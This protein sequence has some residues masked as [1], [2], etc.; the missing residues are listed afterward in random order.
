VRGPAAAQ[1]AAR[2]ATSQAGVRTHR[3]LGALATEWNAIAG[4][5]GNLFQTHEWLSGWWR[6][7]GEGDPSW[8]VLHDRDGS[9]RAGACL[10]PLR[11]NGMTSAANVHSGMWDVL[12]RDEAARA[13]LW[14]AIAGLGA[15]RLHLRGLP[16]AGPS[17]PLVRE[18]LRRAGYRVLSTPG[19]F[20]PW[21]KLPGTWE[22][23][24]GSLSSSMRS[25]MRRTE[26]TLEKRGS[27]TFA[28]ATA[29]AQLERQLERFIA[30]ESS[31]WKG[32]NGS[33][34]A[35]KP[36]TAGLYRD[37]ARAAARRGWM[38]LHTLELDGELIAASFACVFGGECVLLKS[39]FDERRRDLSPG[40]YLLARMIRSAIE[41]EHASS[42]DFLG[43]ADR[44]KLRWAPE[45]RPRMT[46]WAYRGVASPGYTL[47]RRVRPLVKSV[48]DRIRS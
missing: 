36:A 44:Y 28:T 8:M 25:S 47:R 37:F 40:R 23:L 21:L 30:L 20:S 48:R 7:F 18:D 33:A 43:E 39:A 16:Q 9:I 15:N 4:E 12:A 29:G 14:S 10:S 19:P 42:C 17:E 2:P 27:L 3:E 13:Q 34:I 31:G 22:E 32:R 5:S 45:V 11:A 41:Q 26:R 1:E 35:A 6:A 24:C 46:M 38:R